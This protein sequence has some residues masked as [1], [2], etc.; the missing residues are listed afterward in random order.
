MLT[1]E[2]NRDILIFRSQDELTKRSNCVLDIKM[3]AEFVNVCFPPQEHRVRMT[4]ILMS[5]RGS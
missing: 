1:E 4:T 2:H 3:K 5:A